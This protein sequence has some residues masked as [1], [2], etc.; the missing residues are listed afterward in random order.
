MHLLF[1]LHLGATCFMTGVIWFVQLVHYPLFPN[2]ETHGFSSTMKKH[3]SQTSFVVVPAMLLELVTGVW[4]AYRLWH[5]SYLPT[6]A[7]MLLICIW[8]ITFFVSAPLHARL[9]KGFDRQLTTRLVTTNWA[10][11]AMWTARCLLL[12]SL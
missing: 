11:T 7:L 1:N 12:I 3:Q 10:R 4:L 2:F 8:L 6:L 5:L 9:E